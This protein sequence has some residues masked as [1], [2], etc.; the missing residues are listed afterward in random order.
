MKIVLISKDLLDYSVEYANAISHFCT[1]TLCV[2]E[3]NFGQRAEYVNKNIKLCLLNWPRHR[4]LENLR[5]VYQIYKIIRREQPE[6]IHFLSSDVVWLNL[7]IWLTRPIPIVTTVHDIKFHPGDTSS[8]KVP[9]TFREF[10]V[11]HSTAIFVHGKKL[12]EEAQHH[13][14]FKASQIHLVY[15]AARFRYLELAKQ[16]G[17]KKK[18]DGY[19]RVLFFGRIYQYKGLQYFIESEPFVRQVNSKVLF[20]IAGAGENFDQYQALIKNPS[21]F[22]IRNKRIP[23]IEVAQLF[24]DADLVILPYIEASQSGVIPIA[25]T[26]GLPII[27]TNVGS[28]PETVEEGEMGMVI[29]P[30]ETRTL[31]S[32]IIQLCVNK[33]LRITMGEN[34]LKMANSSRSSKGIGEKAFSAY[35]SLI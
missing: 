7:L 4:S 29:P 2:P 24:T 32:A 5:L 16:A 14:K 27:A 3:K 34:A 17:L 11:R 30:R 18:N 9:L 35:Q 28:L 25:M 6:I 8:Q 1:V 20:V 10:I 19:I 33:E 23:D 22:D 26:F 12:L 13:F 15:H 31:A 21:G